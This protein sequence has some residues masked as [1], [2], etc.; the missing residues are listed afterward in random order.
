LKNVSA[1][2]DVFADHF[3]GHPILPG[4]LVVESFQQA[5]Q[6]LIAMSHDF[7]RIGRL[8][9][10]TRVA[11]R[12]FVRPGDQLRLRCERR[13]AAEGWVLAASA[14]VDGRRVAT[15]TLEYAL[16]DAAPGTAAAGAA[17]RLRALV[18]E[19]QQSPLDLA[20][21]GISA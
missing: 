8:T 19:L 11:F 6:I 10:L 16:E 4:A 2:E 15:A 7:T 21:R 14:D 20:P 18:R 3:P 1:T 12:H 13:S 9:R 17:E 5:A